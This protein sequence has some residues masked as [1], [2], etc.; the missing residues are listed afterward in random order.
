MAPVLEATMQAVAATTRAVAAMTRAVATTKA[1]VAMTREV[2]A[3]RKARARALAAATMEQD[4]ARAPGQQTRP[5]R[6]V[7]LGLGRA[8]AAHQMLPTPKPVQAKVTM[9]TLAM[10]RMCEMRPFDRKLWK[11]GV[12]VH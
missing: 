3:T 9:T 2:G 10:V 6:T 5:A 1:V 7:M 8:K 11:L 12:L 4:L